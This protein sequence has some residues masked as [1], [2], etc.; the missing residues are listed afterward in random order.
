MRYNQ[1]NKLSSIRQLAIKR[2]NKNVSKSSCLAVCGIL[3]QFSPFSNNWLNNS[4]SANSASRIFSLQLMRFVGMRLN[5]D[6]EGDD[7]GIAIS[8]VLNEGHLDIL[9]KG[10]R[11]GTG[12]V[13]G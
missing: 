11:Y 13:T 2:C 6:Q 3:N 12:R 8:L 10:Q 1:C 4:D 9:V 7:T 5:T